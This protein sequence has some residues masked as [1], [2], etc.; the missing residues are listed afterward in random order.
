[1]TKFKQGDLQNNT[2]V[3]DNFINSMNCPLISSS[4]GSINIANI[5]TVVITNG[6]SIKAYKGSAQIANTYFNGSRKTTLICSNNF[7]SLEFFDPQ[8]RTM[9]FVCN[10]ISDLSLSAYYISDSQGH[11]HQKIESLTFEDSTTLDL[12]TYS[13]ILNYSKP[14]GYIDYTNS[15]I[16]NNGYKTDIENTEFVACSTVTKDQL[17][18]FRNQNYYSIGTN[19]LIPIDIV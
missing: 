16:F 12:Y 6:N 1:M 8:G 5:F 4:S 2:S 18:T 15:I 7:V 3:W 13:P 17:L 14:F 9:D 19:T 10:N 11:D